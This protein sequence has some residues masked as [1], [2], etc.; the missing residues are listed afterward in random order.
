MAI[1]DAEKMAN[2]I[3]KGL[4]GQD[5]EIDYKEKYFDL[6]EKLKGLIEC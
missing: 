1:F 2:A 3:V 5:V 4:T 6:Q